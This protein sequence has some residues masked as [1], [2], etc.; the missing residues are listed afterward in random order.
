MCFLACFGTGFGY[1]LGV[2]TGSE[3]DRKV[4]P[5]RVLS[6]VIAENR[7]I[8]SQ[9]VTWNASEYGPTSIFSA[10]KS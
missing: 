5:V 6:G 9:I 4:V 3:G 1:G 10:P 8:I 2:Q 7:C